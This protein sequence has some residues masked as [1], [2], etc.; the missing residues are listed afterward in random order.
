MQLNATYNFE[1][2][3][4]VVAPAFRDSREIPPIETALLLPTPLQFSAKASDVRMW[5]VGDDSI[6]S[7]SARTIACPANS[8]DGTVAF[9]CDLA[10][11]GK[12]G[13]ETRYAS[14]W[15]IQGQATFTC[16]SP[17]RFTCR[18]TLL[19]ADGRPVSGW[20]DQL[21]G[22]A[23]QLNVVRMLPLSPRPATV[24]LA[25]P[26]ADFDQVVA[27]VCRAFK[28]KS[29]TQ[30]QVQ[31]WLARP[32]SRKTKAVQKNL[33][34]R[35][36]SG[37]S[38]VGAIGMLPPG[39]YAQ[40]CDADAERVASAS[41]FECEE[42]LFGRFAPRLQLRA[43]ST[44]ALALGEATAT[45][46]RAASA[47]T[48]EEQTLAQAEL[49]AA[50]KEL[51][52]ARAGKHAS[53]AAAKP[54]VDDASDILTNRHTG[55]QREC[56]VKA[57]GHVPSESADAVDSSDGPK[58]P[59]FVDAN[60]YVK[61]PDVCP[62]H[63]VPDRLLRR[64]PAIRYAILLYRALRYLRSRK[65][66]VAVSVNGVGE[67]RQAL[68]GGAS[69]RSNVD[70]LDASQL[71]QGV[72]YLLNR[73]I[74]RK[75]PREYVPTQLLRDANRNYFTG[76][77]PTVDVGGP[78]DTVIAPVNELTNSARLAHTLARLIKS[79]GVA[80][81]MLAKGKTP[82]DP[83]QAKQAAE[84]RA[85]GQRLERFRRVGDLGGQAP[86][87]P[88][89]A[90]IDAMLA[91]IDEWL[92]LA[93]SKVD[94]EGR[95]RLGFKLTPRQKAAFRAIATDGV[96]VCQAGA[97]AGKTLLTAVIYLWLGAAVLTFTSNAAHNIRL[98]IDAMVNA[99]A[100]AR[101]LLRGKDAPKVFRTPRDVDAADVANGQRAVTTMAWI[102]DKAR[103]W[104]GADQST[105]EGQAVISSL[106][107]VL[108]RMRPD[109][110]AYLA[111]DEAACVT[112]RLL[113]VTLKAA[114]KL[115][116]R[117]C[118]LGLLGDKAQLDGVGSGTPMDNMCWHYLG[119][120]VERA[121]DL[122]ESTGRP[123]LENV[124][125][126]QALGA[127]QDV[128]WHRG[129]S[130]HI[131]RKF[132]RFAKHN[133]MG[134][135]IRERDPRLLAPHILPPGVLPDLSAFS[136]G[137]P[138]AIAAL[139]SLYIVPMEPG[140]SGPEDAAF[141]ACSVLSSMTPAGVL[142]RSDQFA[143]VTWRRA[144]VQKV[145]QCVNSALLG[146]IDGVRPPTLRDMRS[147]RLFAGS[148]TVVAA[149]EEDSD[150]DFDLDAALAD[151]APAAAAPAPRTGPVPVRTLAAPWHRKRG[152]FPSTGMYPNL[153]GIAMAPSLG[154]VDVRVPSTSALAPT[155]L[156]PDS[157]IMITDNDSAQ[158]DGPIYTGQT[159]L[160][161]YANI[162]RTRWNGRAKR[163]ERDMSPAG[164]AQTPVVRL[165]PVRDAFIE[166]HVEDGEGNP[167]TVV[168]Y[169]RLKSETT[170]AR[171]STRSVR[172]AVV[173]TTYRAQGMQV[174]VC[175]SVVLSKYCSAKELYVGTTR[176][177]VN[178][179]IV[180]GDALECIVK[181][182]IIPSAGVVGQAIP[183]YL[184]GARVAD[185]LLGKMVAPPPPRAPAPPVPVQ[186]NDDPPPAAGAGRLSL[187]GG[188]AVVE[189]MTARKPPVVKTSSPGL[190]SRR[191]PAV[192]PPPLHTA[193][194]MAIHTKRSDSV[195]V[196]LRPR[197]PYGTLHHAPAAS[198]QGITDRLA[199][200]RRRRAG[201]EFT[202]APAP[203]PED[204]DD[205]AL[206]R[207]LEE[208][209]GKVD[210]KRRRM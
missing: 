51:R 7:G 205:A 191:A 65:N 34:L 133:P 92:P 56:V 123:R 74:E 128:A 134:D 118:H 165:A 151:A 176:G 189:A 186:N 90:E 130:F 114:T 36:F 200:K 108:A 19:G 64:T 44:A 198:Q 136:S 170:G 20:G 6:G 206:L 80:Q 181:R 143:V 180:L 38:D 39:L 71:D 188:K 30:A 197:T 182:G 103:R 69:A 98:R 168:L 208:A 142:P 100:R 12:V 155:H 163:L 169:C 196:E 4:A 43:D 67:D 84:A 54:T 187:F 161:K 194:N 27:S 146:A 116:P 40:L 117:V 76:A 178:V 127:Q 96:M 119:P 45:A 190:H 72:T 46:A 131:L 160:Y 70:V 183:R 59:R 137:D 33:Y 5:R 140:A 28:T 101:T 87:W 75:V 192:A 102:E 113:S 154:D 47:G 57:G 48:K 159:F 58:V 32:G 121:S 55:M 109:S 49:T 122:L 193:D 95:L 202:P 82:L 9:M 61:L 185:D 184:A 172:V 26:R 77:L 63:R 16:R 210:S 110:T 60:G 88:K 52:T 37:A 23:P 125:A 195:D 106:E 173:R 22:E 81:S 158:P 164:S 29:P 167:R 152:G 207:A 8:M 42:Y 145:A 162:V 3:P 174:P 79:A 68:R 105:P 25:L 156:F 132:H 129:I 209:T 135:A 120:D 89:T 14:A 1:L 86:A 2:T 126:L 78:T 11:V 124:R 15:K 203:S 97:G 175:I 149:P 179:V 31:N 91:D 10:S 112:T 144:D 18:Q 73:G 24:K 111:I 138:D 17:P 157:T 35:M 201:G 107:K 62:I 115:L 148:G 41:D 50:Q 153:A 177:Q 199:S 104:L 204:I 166:L 94:R 66:A 141:L 139:D 83:V 13:R 53:E 171:P 21:T 93:T 147:G 150:D 85:T 99:E